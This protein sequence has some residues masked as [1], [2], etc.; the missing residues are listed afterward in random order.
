MSDEPTTDAPIPAG[1]DA[2]AW[3]GRLDTPYKVEVSPG[4]PIWCRQLSLLTELTAGRLPAELEKFVLYESFDGDD[5]KL[6]QGKVVRKTDIELSAEQAERWS[7]YLRIAA[8]AMTWPKLRLKGEPN[9]QAGE[10]APADFT[11]AEI[12]EVAYVATR[13]VVPPLPA[14]F[15]G[16]PAGEPDGERAGQ[17]LPTGD[18]VPHTAE[19]PDRADGERSS[20]PVLAAAV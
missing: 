1:T 4:R 19:P 11:F 6:S 3:K 16:P 5:Y 13:K 9:Y 20:E 15:S 14:M 17:P 2:S 18:A 7:N 12:R 10:A 8:R